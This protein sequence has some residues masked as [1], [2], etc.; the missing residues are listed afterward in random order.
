MLPGGDTLAGRVARAVELHGGGGTGGAGARRD[1][2]L[3]DSIARCV[4]FLG[5]ARRS[6]SSWGNGGQERERKLCVARR[7]WSLRVTRVSGV[8][9]PRSL[10]T[11][12]PPRCS[13]QNLPHRQRCYAAQRAAWQSDSRGSRPQDP[14]ELRAARGAVELRGV[15]APVRRGLRSRGGR[16]CRPPPIELQQPSS[17]RQP[18]PARAVKSG[19]RHRSMAWPWGWAGSVTSIGCARL[20]GG[21]S[22]YLS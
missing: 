22:H 2:A 10:L 3:R 21:L 1:V 6:R 14:G 11:A 19:E 4:A 9:R 7:G 15:S 17:Q 16:S 12:L 8:S 13:L 18:S 5:T 20:C